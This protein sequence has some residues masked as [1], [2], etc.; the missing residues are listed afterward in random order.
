MQ[1]KREIRSNNE[2][3]QPSYNY[4]LR[5]AEEYYDNL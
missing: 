1:K 5:S 2:Y 3:V 4:D